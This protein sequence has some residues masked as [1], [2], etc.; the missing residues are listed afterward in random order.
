MLGTASRM[1]CGGDMV[2]GYL[3]EGAGRASGRWQT[4]RDRETDRETDEE[5]D[6]DGQR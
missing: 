6:R 3:A 1:P 4:E 2:F 5:T